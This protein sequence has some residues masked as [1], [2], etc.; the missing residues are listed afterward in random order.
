MPITEEERE[1]AA[2]I[3][4]AARLH[5]TGD[6]AGHTM[7]AQALIGAG[8][9][10]ALIARGAAGEA[11]VTSVGHRRGEGALRLTRAS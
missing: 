7:E 10:A 11:L 6:L 1:A 5:A 3:A 9:A 8:L 2:A 4:A